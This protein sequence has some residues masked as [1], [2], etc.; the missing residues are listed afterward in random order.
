MQNVYSFGEPVTTG[1]KGAARLLK[2]PEKIK[3]I[4]KITTFLFFLACMQVSAKSDAQRITLS[5]KNASIEKVFKEI[6]VQS[7]Y[8]FVYNNRI[9]KNAKKVNVDFRNQPIEVV[10]GNILQDQPFT[11]SIIDKTIVLKPL[12]KILEVLLP[13]EVSYEETIRGKV[14]DS[15]GQPLAR[16][17]VKVKG[18]ATATATDDQGEFVLRVKDEKPVLVFSMIGYATREVTVT[19]NQTLNIVLSEELKQLGDVIVTGIYNRKASSYKGAAVT[20][21]KKE[22]KQVGNANVFQALKNLAPSMVLDNF[23]VGSDPNALPN[24]QIRG[25]SSFPLTESELTSSLKGNY[26]KN[27]NEPLFI[28][29]GFETSIENV[30][31]LDMNRIETITILKD[32][33][34]KALYG[35]KAANGVIVIETTKLSSNKPLVTYNASVDVE[36]P[37]LS[38]Y[39][40]ANSAEKL[41]AERIDGMYTAKSNTYDP[42]GTNAN[43]MQLYNF[44]RKLVLEGMD[45][46]WMAKPLR[47]GVGQKHALS[48]ELGGDNL[49][50]VADGSYR[51]VAGVMKGSS[52]K[53]IAGSMSTSYRVSNLLF[54]NIT[55]INSNNSFE[56]PYGTFNE[57]AR[58][59]P[60][61]KAVNEDGT[62]PYYSELGPNGERF[63]NPLYN[64]T[65]N[66]KITAD[67]FN[68]VNNF[69]MEWTIK[70]GL[71]AT[72]RAGINVNKNGADE[73][74]PSGH[75][76][77]DL[78]LS[79]EDKNRRGSYQ[80]N[81]GKSISLFGD[82]NLNYTK[83]INKHALFGN[84]G[85]NVSERK[86]SEVF[87]L[88]E[89]FASDR[90]NN[91]IFGRDY[92]LDSRPSGV[93]GINREIG[94]LGAA[95]YVWD[96]R[97]L[98]DLTLRTTASSQ[99][100]ADKRW[101]NFWSLGLGWNLHKEQ[102]FQ[103]IGI[104]DQFKL[105]G[106]LG[107][108]GSQNFS[109]NQSIATY[110]YYLQSLYQGFP[111]SYLTNLANPG[112]QWESSFDY[113][114]GLDLK[115]KG[116][117]IR[118]DYYE[119]Y[120][121]NLVTLIT[122]PES[123][124]FG[125]VSDN[126]GKVKNEGVEI[127]AS[128]LV[129][130]SG[131][132]FVN[133]NASFE[134][135]TNK[136]VELSNSMKDFNDRMNKLAADRSNNKPVNR[137]EDGM[138]MDAI[139]AVPSLGIDPATGNEIYMDRNGN[140]TYNWSSSDM[141]VAGNAAPKYQGIF[142]FN[143]EV[144]NFGLGVTGRYLAGGQLYNQTLVDRVENI[145]MNYN[146]DKRVLNGRWLAPGQHV[147]FKRLGQ[148]SR[149]IE[150]SNASE[151]RDEKTR[152]TTIFVQDRNEVTIGA[153][154]FYYDFTDMIRNYKI[155]RLRA[156]FNM[157]EVAT[158]STIRL[159]RGLHYPFAR[160][161][162]FSVSATF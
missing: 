19:S 66:S 127:Y 156:S 1:L 18:V 23:V 50:I 34:S 13:K 9:L 123:T 25:N 85:F 134:T 78:Y 87:H 76:K 132:N 56:S 11:F 150:G 113:N 149:P 103:N 131:K 69:Y 159:E 153:I 116:L 111:G 125:F 118:L 71:R 145:D 28:L 17:T 48:V 27:P 22:L 16:V 148:Y 141:I 119:R 92:A 62:I 6:N 60:Y 137:Y 91:I 144:H 138:S 160:T 63:T 83:E 54:R 102:F 136:I 105:R 143:A 100:G 77:F 93:D 107:N 7:G 101:G 97:F 68:V 95:S 57:Y 84:I 155:Q 10:L 79:E 147:E 130:S 82:V 43:L 44:R 80:V 61:W 117:S 8:N 4:M 30:F 98:T 112:L 142:S 128:Y 129:W 38:S 157:N 74:Y 75:T 51:E 42:P 88:V 52:R 162:S 81:N 94:F 109:T 158:F 99:F 31:D 45:T 135:N 26:L 2:M 139:W 49:R 46:Y 121:E 37:D 140:T 72:T 41:E 161:L 126:L 90:M 20:I 47:D 151:S 146:V 21:T 114:A 86:Y 58:M 55:S 12:E 39:N 120:K 70:P 152:A 110:Q 24:I 96:N 33:A 122:L 36:L 29:D 32:A 115:V 40:L 15:K 73:F 14:V 5:L 53:N 64:S 3:K 65:V 89:G 154:N 35:S 67:Y 59:N 106:S 108:T 124:G 133:L 104:F